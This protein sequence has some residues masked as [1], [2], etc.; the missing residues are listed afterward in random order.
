MEEKTAD[1]GCHQNVWQNKGDANLAVNSAWVIPFV[2]QERRY[3]R[4]ILYNCAE[5]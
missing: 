2:V 3:V 4:G 1:K 5:I